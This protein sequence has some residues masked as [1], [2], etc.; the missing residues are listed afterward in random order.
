MHPVPGRQVGWEEV[1]AAWEQIAGLNSGGQVTVHDLRIGL[2]SDLAH[3]IGT[4]RGK[5]E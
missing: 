3:T 4:E 1:R 2:G 5:R